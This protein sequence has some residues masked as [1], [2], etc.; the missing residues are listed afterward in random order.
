[1]VEFLLSECQE[2]LEF[3]AAESCEVELLNILKV[4]GER[5]GHSTEAETGLAM[6]LLNIRADSRHG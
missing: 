3:S 6:T 2:L 4:H 1:M 5:V